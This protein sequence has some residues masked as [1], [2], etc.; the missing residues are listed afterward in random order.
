MDMINYIWAALIVIGFVVGVATGNL[1]AVSDAAMNSAKDSV[2]LCFSLV[3]V[4]ALWMG[5]L[6]I[7]QESGMVQGIAKKC[8]RLICR[9]FQGVKRGSEALGYIS[10]NLVANMLG[11]G[12]AATPFGLKAMAELQKMNPDKKVASNAMCML[13]I[14]N[15]SSVQ[16]LPLTIIGLRSAAGAVNPA[17]ITITALVATTVTTLTAIIIAKLCE[18]SSMRK[19]KKRRRTE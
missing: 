3:G 10:L 7:A 2:T 9:L 18:K 15:A 14:I 16:L 5:I 19:N 11:M 4:Y 13:L 12:N 6:K 1:E 8:E 17:D